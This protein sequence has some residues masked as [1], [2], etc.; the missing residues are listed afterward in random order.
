MAEAIAGSRM[1]RDEVIETFS[2]LTELTNFLVKAR[3]NVLPSLSI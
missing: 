1:E 2:F 3:R